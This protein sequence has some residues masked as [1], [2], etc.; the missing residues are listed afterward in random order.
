MTEQLSP[1]LTAEEASRRIA[2][3]IRAYPHKGPDKREEHHRLFD[4]LLSHDDIDGAWA[5]RYTEIALAGRG[6]LA[7][8]S[9]R[10][11]GLRPKIDE[12]KRKLAATPAYRRIASSN[13]VV[14][15]GIASFILPATQP[16]ADE[17]REDTRRAIAAKI[18]RR[19]FPAK[20][21]IPELA[22]PPVLVRKNPMDNAAA[23]ARD[24]LT[25]HKG[26]YAPLAPTSTVVTGGNGTEHL[27]NQ[28]QMTSAY[29]TCSAIT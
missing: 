25:Y 7:R 6:K 3:D 5:D 18:I 13:H 24:M 28:P 11:E 19:E 27:M 10:L 15:S 9:S 21:A 4:E 8:L 2:A 29:G 22:E 14:N 17:T 16:T 20:W 26:I 23:F 12:A 1:Q